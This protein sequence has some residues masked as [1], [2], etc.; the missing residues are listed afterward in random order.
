MKKLKFIAGGQP[1]RSTDFEVLQNANI[2]SFKELL[3]GMTN[4]LAI[5]SGVA[6]DMPIVEVLNT[7]FT[8]SAGY[9]YDLVELCR[10]P[11][12]TFNFN[13]TKALY[14]RLQVLDTSERLIGGS[15]LAVMTERLYNLQYYSGAAVGGD[16]ALSA[17]PR[18]AM[19]TK[20]AL[21]IQPGGHLSSLKTGFTATVG[22]GLYCHTNDCGEALIRCTFTATTTS[23]ALC[24][25]LPAEMRP[26]VE[27]LGF[28]MAGTS[29]RPLLIKTDGNIEVSGVV[30]SGSNVIMFRYS[31]EFTL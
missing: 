13:A 16:I 11:A 30:T 15:T 1:F 22:S 29:I 23:G 20:D 4:E 7:P 31:T 24:D 25:V 2:Q 5:L 3:D 17:V 27:T 18:L 21:L 6:S 10:V 9:V 28:F 26:K 19:V 14:L 8:I 12:A